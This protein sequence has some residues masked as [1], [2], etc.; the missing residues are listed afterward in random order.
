[1]KK[2]LRSMKLDK[3]FL[4][5]GIIIFSRVEKDPKFSITKNTRQNEIDR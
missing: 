1:M 3:N 4:Q 5:A 2:L